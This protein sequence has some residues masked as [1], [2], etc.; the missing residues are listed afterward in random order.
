[1]LL[2]GTTPL[3]HLFARLTALLAEF[4]DASIVL[5]A[6]G[7]G[8]RARVAYVYQEGRGGAPDV[9]AI[10]PSST[11]DTVL[12]TGE[13]K[14]YTTLADWP[15]QNALSLDGAELHLPE[16]AVFVPILFGGATVGALS[17]QSRVPN[18]YDADDVALLETCGL[19]LGARIADEQQREQ[20]AQL[21]H[22]ALTDALT[23]LA[24]RRAFDEAFVREW[25]RCARSGE[26]FSIALLD[27]D[28]F[29]SFNDTY[30]HVA[31]DACLRQVAQAILRC[32]KRP[33]DLV[34][35]YG[36]EE[37]ALVM[38]ATD[39]EGA[40]R[41]CESACEAIRALNVPHQEST[42]GC[43]TASVGLFTTTPRSDDADSQS[44]LS[45]ADALLYR[46]KSEGRNRVAAAGYLSEAV[47]AR[48]RASQRGNVPAPRTSFIGRQTDVELILEG[49][50]RGR[51]VTIAGTGGVG[52][53][54]LA[55]E[56]AR[57][58]T[59][60]Y[61]DGTWFV[62]LAP[63]TDAALVVSAIA[64]AVGVDTGSSG[65]PLASLA[66]QL[67]P[68]RVLLV[69][70]NCEH[71]IGE[72][73][74][75]I[76]VLLSS[77]AQLSVLATSRE[78]MHIA[79]ESVHRLPPFDDAA[80]AVL[81]RARAIDAGA[82]LHFDR[83]DLDAIAN[84]CRRLDG[85]PLAIELAA[86]RTRTL[87]PSRIQQL[88]EERFR[89]LAGGSRTALP[90]HQTLRG[91]IDW[92]YDLLSGMERRIFARLAVFAGSF[93]AEAAAAVAIETQDR[94]TAVDT[95]DALVDK[96]MLVS[97]DGERYRLLDSLLDYA[98]EKLRESG[99]EPMRRMLHASYY[100]AASDWFLEMADDR[101]SVAWMPRFEL[102]LDDFRAAIEWSLERDLEIAARIAGNLSNAWDASGLHLE[103][104]R[105]IRRTLEALGESARNPKYAQL[106][107]AAGFAASA[108]FKST[109]SIEASQVA[110]DLA[111][112]ADQPL[113]VA[114]AIEVI[115]LAEHRFGRDPKRAHAL[116]KEAVG[117]CRSLRK[118][119]RTAAVLA[120]YAAS[121]IRGGDL[122]EARAC[123]EEA[124]ALGQSAGDASR[125][126]NAEVNLAEIEFAL[127]RIDRACE[128]ARHCVETFRSNASALKLANALANFA[129]YEAVA[130][131]PQ[132]AAPA[133]REAIALAKPYEAEAHV[134]IAAQAL[135]LCKAQGGSWE[136]A[137]RLLGFADAVYDRR[138]AQR[139][140]TEAT[141]RYCI[142]E[143]LA[144]SATQPEIEAEMSLGRALD[145][146]A[147]FRLAMD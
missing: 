126:G 40:L 135:A 79:G 91:L 124:A 103:G 82:H 29:K 95:L 125:A 61:P 142:V 100:A 2:S 90:R 10:V 93:T 104:Y 55:L 41:L 84:I 21:E 25:R 33:G 34:V 60:G 127:G 5:V 76:D 73:A 72:I 110:L 88:I 44:A 106:W 132:E 137:A 23:G 20:T 109:E 117:L 47:P 94:W 101:P 54:R 144:R 77:C 22:L 96:S 1:M 36:G 66:A 43:V 9:G 118:P 119:L 107:L 81:F 83:G 78:P 130:D 134:A 28:Y 18:A 99:E 68:Q 46:A 123:F 51:L 24:N 86:A 87:P 122:E 120:N 49:L 67:R 35:R 59:E 50:R 14:L 105:T 65:D 141:V 26:A 17:V 13:A 6:I 8:D 69:V 113:S 42:L 37:F 48:V 52:K 115:G 63:L 12:R 39:Q 89:F 114:K 16:S 62:D 111:R 71:V 102:E 58:C 32:F 11:T 38:P 4:V 116:L 146:D 131:R 53:T 80:A 129:S 98:R 27:V 139:E 121:L 136:E 56:V 108:L 7:S 147:L 85:L 75:A 140:P 74:H 112:A 70:D 133:A 97:V 19:Y 15:S 30:G 64:V 145:L 45:S 31:G 92:S 57:Q 3:Q 143:S 128:I 138:G